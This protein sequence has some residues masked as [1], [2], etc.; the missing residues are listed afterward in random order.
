MIK[1]MKRR[2]LPNALARAFE[3]HFIYDKEPRGHL[4]HIPFFISKVI[5]D[6]Y[7]SNYLAIYILKRFTG[8]LLGYIFEIKNGEYV[9]VIPCR[10]S[11]RDEL[12]FLIRDCLQHVKIPIINLFDIIFLGDIVASPGDIIKINISKTFK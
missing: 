6:L 7:N 10:K 12:L 1:K 5:N 2:T 3:R 8:L 11:E 4:R 9:L